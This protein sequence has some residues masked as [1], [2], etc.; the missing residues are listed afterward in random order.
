[1]TNEFPP[2]RIWLQGDGRDDDTTWAAN[3]TG[4]DVET[5]YVRADV[6]EEALSALKGLMSN[7]DGCIAREK[8]AAAIAKLEGTEN[9]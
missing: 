8:A 2:R 1:M 5:A 3:E 7:P 9:G 6:A 4:E